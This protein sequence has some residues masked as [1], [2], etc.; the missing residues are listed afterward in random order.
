MNHLIRFFIWGTLAAIQ[1]F[2]QEV[3]FNPSPFFRGLARSNS[4][5]SARAGLG[6]TTNAVM[7][8]YRPACRYAIKN[9]IVTSNVV[10][11]I[12]S[13]STAGTITEL[14]FSISQA[15]PYD[16]VVTNAGAVLIF[17]IDGV[18]NTVPIASYFAIWGKPFSFRASGTIEC[19]FI[20]NLE[21]SLHRYCEINYYTN[22]SIGLLLPYSTGI[23]P[24]I[25]YRIGAAPTIRYW[26]CKNI[27]TNWTAGK[28]LTASLS[29]NSRG[30]LE[31]VTCFKGGYSDNGWAW[32]EPL[33]TFEF[34]GQTNKTGGTEDFF[35]GYG[36]F[37]SG[38]D[39][40]FTP[41]W[42][43]F[44]MGITS[45]QLYTNLNASRYCFTGYR[46]FNKEGEHLYF[47]NYLNFNWLEYPVTYPT[48]NILAISYWDTNNY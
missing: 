21:L 30:E 5:E 38:S 15:L 42:G 32:L 10:Y 4:A 41:K 20:S 47:T 27:M 40:F 26:H 1:A 24:N 2:G 35:G 22:C 6:I 28:G 7:V 46:F 17:V 9:G 14:Q 45:L 12:F 43:A 16:F 33:P 25:A 34:D 44:V 19:P 3:V 18:T 48:T 31:A 11:P 13:A 37:D 39:T 23:W 8:D 36:Y 29:T